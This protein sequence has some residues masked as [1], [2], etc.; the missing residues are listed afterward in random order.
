M[1][2][3]AVELVRELRYHDAPPYERIELNTDLIVRAS[4]QTVL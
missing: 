2:A 3:R 1:A 4:T